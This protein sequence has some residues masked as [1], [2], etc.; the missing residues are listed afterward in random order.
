MT[1]DYDIFVSH[2]WADGELP[3]QIADAL[4]DAGLRVWFDATEINDFSSITR[5]VNKGLSKSKALLAY[6]S[7]PYPL[8]RA[9]QWELTAA[10]LA[11]QSE[12]D[13]R[14]RVLVINPEPGASHIHP[15]E[16]RDAKFRTLLKD[17]GAALQELAQS[18]GKHVA[19]LDGPLADIHS[20]TAPQWYGRSPVGSTR[21]VGRLAEMWQLHSLL[22]AADVAQI[23]GA[24]VN[25][26]QVTGLGG[27]GKSLLAEEYALHFGAAYPGGVFWL[28]AYGNDDAKSALG[29]EEREAER[30]GQMQSMAERL[31]VTTQ[32]MTLAQ[33]EGALGREIERRRK[34][35]LWVVDDVPNGLDG[36]A[37]PRWFAPHPLARTLITT[38]S[39]EY[40]SLASGIDLSVLAP[41]EAH[42]LLISRRQ[43]SDAGE[44]EQ[45]HLLAEDLG[46]HA[47]ALDVTASALQ[48]SVAAAPFRNFRTKLSRPDKDAMEL[49]AELADALPNRREKS[50]AQTLLHSIRNLGQ[51]GLDFLR[52]ASVL[53][54]A[55]IPAS[56]VT[57]ALEEADKLSHDDAEER[58][59]LAIKQLT[60]SSLAEKAG[61]NQE[62]CA[63]HTLVSRTVR[64]WEKSK[65]NAGNHRIWRG[66]FEHIR[67]RFRCGEPSRT[68]VLRRAAVEA[69][70]AT[71]GRDMKEL[72]E[73]DD[74]FPM[75][76]VL[77]RDLFWL[78]GESTTLG[79]LAEQ[80][81]VRKRLLKV[82]ERTRKNWR[83][84]P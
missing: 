38:R 11:A 67:S 28:R 47:L 27:V 84:R 66:A 33:I 36:E 42:Q 48:R 70:M 29:P 45:A 39:R 8:R 30:A 26:G 65:T 25:A 64:F 60:A 62:A 55:P 53:P 80:K 56:L 63:V 34:R 52:L 18:V 32:D 19:R 35:C 23:T 54:V 12:G 10:F 15:I 14:R 72:A 37:L 44:E 7:K 81:R 68:R 78:F 73:V 76:E 5:A 51:E 75:L 41:D 82:I 13:P 61:E 58:T 74:K 9:C 49:A 77:Q 57:A 22:N 50:I 20:L 16:L 43:A 40:R 31:G 79:G 17:N 59:S 24:V 4:K 1:A 21:F 46:R 83:V 71:I 69:V 2:A 6:Y 3:G